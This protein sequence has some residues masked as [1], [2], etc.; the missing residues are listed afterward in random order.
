MRV[1]P[2]KPWFTSFLDILG[3]EFLRLLH[4]CLASRLNSTHKPFQL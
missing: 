4:R 3:A 2:S 1:S